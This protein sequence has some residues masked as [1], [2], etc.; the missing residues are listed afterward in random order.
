MS[1]TPPATP[2]LHKNACSLCARRKVKCDKKDPCSNCLKAQT[3]CSYET[4]A[5]P[6][7]RKRAADQ[8][9]LARL[10][11]YEDLMRKHNVDFTQHAN[12]WVPCELEGDLKASG[13]P[14]L[15]VAPQE[16]L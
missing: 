11:Q 1:P 13:S 7:P 5:P 9:L 12:I 15:D 4:P 2:G 14:A 8:D 10:A 6:R 16:E 3:Q